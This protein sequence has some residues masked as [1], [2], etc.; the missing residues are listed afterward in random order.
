MEKFGSLS[1]AEGLTYVNIIKLR[2]NQI[3]KVQGKYALL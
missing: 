3:C 2:I 1:F